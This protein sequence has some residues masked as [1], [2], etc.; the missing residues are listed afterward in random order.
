MGFSK[1]WG[2][3]GCLLAITVL[4]PGEAGAQTT[5]ADGARALVVGDYETAI[6]ILRPLAE[7]TAQ[8]DQLAQFFLAMLYGSLRGGDDRTCGLYLAAAAGTNPLASQSLVLARAI[9]DQLGPLAY[10]CLQQMPP[11]QPLPST[12]FTR[13]PVL[14]AAAV[15]PAQ[16]TTPDGLEAFVRGDYQLAAEILKPI[17]DKSPLPDDA[18]KFLMGAMY[19]NGLGVAADQ[20]RACA[21]YMQAAGRGGGGTPFAVAANTMVRALHESMTR[22]EFDD[23]ELFSYLGFDHGFQPVTFELEPGHWISWDL[24]GATISYGGKETRIQRRPAVNQ[25][26]IVFLPLHHTV[27]T[28]GPSGSI[29]RHFIEVSV[30]VP[31]R[32]RQSWT[33]RWELYEVVRNELIVVSTESSLTTISAQEPPTAPPF[34]VDEFARVRVDDNGNAEWA[35]LAGPRKRTEAIQSDAERQEEKQQ[36]LALAAADA[37][38]DWKLERDVRRTPALTYVDGNGCGNV[39]VY[40]WSDDRTEAISVSAD[41]NLLQLSTTARTFDMAATQTGLEVVVHL[42]PRPLRSWPFCT[43]APIRGEQETWRAIGGTVTIELTARGVSPRQPN[44]YRATIRI[45]GAEFVNSSGVRVKQVRPIT[46]TAMVGWQ[47]G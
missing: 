20:T 32:D 37:R 11:D 29:R 40:G 9:Q 47:S 39:F 38:L 15:A 22:E 41:T 25:P 30:W 7:N 26:G 8:P 34:D 3:L 2:V 14:V 45:S 4:V 33:L 17:A 44:L 5:T 24:K 6:R 46:L 10:L 28:V 42:Y 1:R 43:D 35:V 12:S 27:L 23:C 21:S 36:K 16:T 19:E 13:G 18:A 31:A